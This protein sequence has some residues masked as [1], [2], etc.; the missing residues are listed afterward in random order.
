MFDQRHQWRPIPGRV[1]DQDRFVMQA[2]LPPGQNLEQFIQG[3]GPAGQHDH[4]IGVHE[5]DLFAL[6]H[7]FGHHV[8][9]Q[10]G[11]ADLPGHQM[12]RNHA[13]RVPAGGLCCAR[14][15]AHQADIARTIDQ[16][17]A[18]LCNGGADILGGQRI[19]GHCPRARS[20]I[21]TDG[22]GG[23]GLSSP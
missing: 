2:Q 7:G 21:D 8:S 16:P 20:A 1:Q 18:F 5:H 17:P 13:K 11:L 6:V 14:N 15:L 4:R 12:R 23:H 22:F 10:V 19:G 3:S 9:R